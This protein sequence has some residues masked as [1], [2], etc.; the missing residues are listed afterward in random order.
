MGLLILFCDGNHL[1][2]HT[3]H[4]HNNYHHCSRHLYWGCG[5]IYP[6]TW[7]VSRLRYKRNELHHLH[8]PKGKTD[9]QTASLSHFTELFL[10]WK[11]IIMAWLTKFFRRRRQRT[12][13]R[14]YHVVLPDGT[15]RTFELQVRAMWLVIFFI[16]T[17]SVLLQCKTSSKSPS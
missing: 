6:P 14:Q 10:Q 15:E 17:N 13:T 11:I 9:R 12:M 4:S 7:R 1:L 16:I 8:T 3:T 5:L 2:P